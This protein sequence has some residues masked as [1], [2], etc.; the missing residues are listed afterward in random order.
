MA[1]KEEDYGMTW[2]TIYHPLCGGVKNGICTITQKK[3]YKYT[4]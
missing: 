4:D 1:E 3:I 2:G